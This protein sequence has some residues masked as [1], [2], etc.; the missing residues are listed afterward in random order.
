MACLVDDVGDE[1]PCLYP[2][3]CCWLPS[4]SIDDCLTSNIELV[5]SVFRDF[6]G[7]RV[8]KELLGIGEVLIGKPSKEF[9]GCSCSY[10]S[11]DKLVLDI[12]GSASHPSGTERFCSHLP[13]PRACPRFT[14]FS[15][16]FGHLEHQLIPEPDELSN[17]LF[18]ASH[19]RRALPALRKH[20]ES[21]SRPAEH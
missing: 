13:R 19:L 17:V 7:R 21:R 15:W 18:G 8:S 11:L 14:G 9:A 1:V 6:P 20:K 2:A 16:G 5:R 10:G 12:F 4:N 3:I